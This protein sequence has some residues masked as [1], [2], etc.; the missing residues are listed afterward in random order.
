MLH[1]L[2]GIYKSGAFLFCTFL[3]VIAVLVFHEMLGLIIWNNH[4]LADRYLHEPLCL[5]CILYQRFIRRP[6]RQWPLGIRCAPNHT[7]DCAIKATVDL[8]S[9]C[10]SSHQQQNAAT[11]LFIFGW[12]FSFANLQ[13]PQLKKL[14]L[15]EYLNVWQLAIVITLCG[16][17]FLTYCQKKMN[18]KCIC[19]LAASPV[20]FLF[21]LHV[22]GL[23]FNTVDR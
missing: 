19:K 1:L 7:P 11:G 2:C 12:H 4:W 18:V 17:Q 22:W 21:F 23:S 5:L 14:S 6:P 9:E 8:K 3:L 10:L 13:H 15:M 20:L 16:V